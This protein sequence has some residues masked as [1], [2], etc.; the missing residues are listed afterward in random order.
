MS[1][2]SDGFTQKSSGF[3]RVNESKLSSTTPFPSDT[4]RC[5]P[6]P[7]TPAAPGGVCPAGSCPRHPLRTEKRRPTTAAPNL[8]GAT[9][10]PPGVG[11]RWG[12]G[13][14]G[15]PGVR[16]ARGPEPSGRC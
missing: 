15:E 5:Q 11:T 14:A 13:A 10:E 4:P 3:V 6:A 8:T 12:R 7:L 16:A 2:T 1:L 9:A